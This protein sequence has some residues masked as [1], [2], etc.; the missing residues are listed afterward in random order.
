VPHPDLHSVLPFCKSA[1]LPDSQSTFVQDEPILTEEFLQL[2]NGENLAVKVEANALILHPSAVNVE[3]Q[4]FNAAQI[5]SSVGRVSA[6]Q[7]I[8]HNLPINHNVADAI[9]LANQDLVIG[10]KLCHLTPLSR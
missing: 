1:G 10:L 9:L 8:G 7:F 4:S 3:L 2:R 6:L 5:R